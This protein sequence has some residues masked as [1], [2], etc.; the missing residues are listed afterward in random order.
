MNKSLADTEVKCPLLADDLVLLSPTKD[1]L[2]QHLDLLHQFPQSWAE[3]AVNLIKTNILIFQTEYSLQNHNY[4]LFLRTTALEHTKKLYV[5]GSKHQ[6]HRSLQHSCE[7]PHTSKTNIKL[8]IPV[9]LLLKILDS[10]IEPTSLSGSQNGSNTKLRLL[11]IRPVGRIL[12]GS[13]F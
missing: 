3:L 2:Q 9:L 8:D 6:E 5:P 1:E 12:P 10:I 11:W 7:W 13:S 4:Q